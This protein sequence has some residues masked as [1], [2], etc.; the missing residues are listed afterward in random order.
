[1]KIEKRLVKD[2]HDSQKE[3]YNGIEEIGPIVHYRRI[4]QED[5]STAKKRDQYSCNAVYIAKFQDEVD[6]VILD[7]INSI[8]KLTRISRKTLINKVQLIKKALNST[9]RKRVC[10]LNRTRGC[11]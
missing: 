9:A 7:L 8:D 10:G 6:N 11:F 4:F 5:G 2:L 3:F 1:M